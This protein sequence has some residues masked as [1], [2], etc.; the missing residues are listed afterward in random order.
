MAIA[1]VVWDDGVAAG[2]PEDLLRD[3]QA[4]WAAVQERLSADHGVASAE[5]AT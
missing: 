1:E 5:S 3:A 4:G 2:T